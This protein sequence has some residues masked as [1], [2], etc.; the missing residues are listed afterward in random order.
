MGRLPDPKGAVV[1]VRL[2]PGLRSPPAASVMEVGQIP[3]H[4]VRSRK[5]AMDAHRD[6]STLVKSVR[7][8][9]D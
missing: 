8:R 2:G 7:R 1:V 5:T 6:L 4:R 9:R 3:M